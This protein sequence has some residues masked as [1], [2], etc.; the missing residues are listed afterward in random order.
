[1]QVVSDPLEMHKIRI[2][3]VAGSRVL[4]NLNISNSNLACSDKE[5]VLVA[6]EI[7]QTN[8]LWD[9]VCLELS[10]HLEDCLVHHK[11]SNTISNNIEFSTT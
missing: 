3:M 6:Q 2:R 7:R 1:M 11:V 10:N 9:K 5:S 4:L 8:P